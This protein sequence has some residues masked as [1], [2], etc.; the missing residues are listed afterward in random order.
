[1]GMRIALLA[2]CLSGCASATP[3][4]PSLLPRAIETRSDAEPMVAAGPVADDA[5]LDAQIA[6]KRRAFDAA[7]A[8]FEKTADAVQPRVER[9]VGAAEGSERWIAA[10]TALG[11]LGQARAGS[12]AALAELEALAVARASAGLPPYPALEAAVAEAQQ[13]IDR[14]A[15][16]D[17]ALQVRIA[18]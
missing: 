10:Q 7:R 14:Q 18:R 11:E 5:A 17:A 16:V 8:M 1:M 2:L 3:G 13:E 15:S 4:V 12:D 6:E 9:A